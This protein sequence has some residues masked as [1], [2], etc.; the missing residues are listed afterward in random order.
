MRPNFPLLLSVSISLSSGLVISAENEGQ[1]VDDYANIQDVPTIEEVVIT[2]TRVKKEWER[3]YQNV[4]GKR[5]FKGPYGDDKLII[6]IS[7]ELK[8]RGEKK[9]VFTRGI[10]M[11][12]SYASSSL[13]YYK[14]PAE[15]ECGINHFSFYE[16]PDFTAL[17]YIK[18]P[19][20][21]LLDV[22]TGGGPFSA[23][24]IWGPY[25]QIV[26]MHHG[27]KMIMGDAAKDGLGKI[28]GGYAIGMQAD[29]Q[30]YEMQDHG[31]GYG[32]VIKTTGNCLSDKLNAE[33]ANR[34]LSGK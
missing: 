16:G 18:G 19:K 11:P 3:K 23:P 27:M 1:D 9:R 14:Y 26:G 30:S 5:V 12:Q 21:T 4:A 8:N 31:D 2:G 17:G 34:V 13:D 7:Q 20:E 22:M 25:D 15:E 28:K 6:A 10:S 33:A 24:G 29:L 32:D